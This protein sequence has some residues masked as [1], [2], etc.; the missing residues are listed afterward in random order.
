MSNI[1]HLVIVRPDIYQSLDKE[2]ADAYL[3][4]NQRVLGI[5]HQGVIDLGEEQ[6]KAKSGYS[7][8]RLPE[9]SPHVTGPFVLDD[10]SFTITNS[11]KRTIEYQKAL[12]ACEHLLKDVNLDW[13]AQSRRVGIRTYKDTHTKEKTP[14]IRWDYLMRHVYHDLAAV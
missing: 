12:D 7:S 11:V 10:I 4:A 6:L 5:L 14:F 3:I 2:S 8:A 9:Y 13:K 1:E